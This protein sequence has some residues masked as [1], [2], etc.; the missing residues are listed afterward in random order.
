MKSLIEDLEELDYENKKSIMKL[1]RNIDSDII[2]WSKRKNFSQ[3]R[4]LAKLL[5][6]F[7][8]INSNGLYHNRN[9]R[10]FIVELLR[11]IKKCDSF[12]G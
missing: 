2:F 4:E 11:L 9:K 7:A 10:N 5:R 6:N 8:S 3:L 1:L 12:E